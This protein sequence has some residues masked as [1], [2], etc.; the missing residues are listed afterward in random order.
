MTC[1]VADDRMFSEDIQLRT[2]FRLYNIMPGN[3]F[4]SRILH[5][6]HSKHI[7]GYMILTHDGRRAFGVMDGKRKDLNRM[8]HCLLSF[9][10]PEPFSQRVSFSAYEICVNPSKEDFN[11]KYSVPKDATFLGDLQEDC[12]LRS[13]DEKKEPPEE[14]EESRAVLAEYADFY[15]AEYFDNCASTVDTESYGYVSSLADSVS[16]Q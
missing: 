6:C 8:K 4:R 5:Y 14:T 16:S 11:I 13:K 1:K 15:N 7:T 9:F 2:E 10:I 12:F 3:Q